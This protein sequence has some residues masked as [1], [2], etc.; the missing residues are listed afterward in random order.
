MLLFCTHIKNSLSRSVSSQL[1]SCCILAA[2]LLERLEH[3]SGSPLTGGV[4]SPVPHQ[5]PAGLRGKGRTG[6]REDSSCPAAGGEELERREEPLWTSWVCRIFKSLL[7]QV[8]LL[9]PS[10]AR[11]NKH[12]RSFKHHLGESDLI[13]V[14][15]SSH[16]RGAPGDL[17]RGSKVTAGVPR[18][19]LEAPQMILQSQS[20]LRRSA[21]ED[22]RTKWDQVSSSRAVEDLL[23]APLSH[24]T[25]CLLVSFIQRQQ[26]T[27]QRTKNSESE[28]ECLR[29]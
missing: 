1:R 28:C 3:P 24:T 2:V 15:C 23:P 4:S 10:P 12:W 21:P 14:Q 29:I 13:F 9:N 27:S 16:E 8:L 20:D 17:Q 22:F 7:D 18:D 6:G 25:A 19:E 11:R 5:Q 26:P